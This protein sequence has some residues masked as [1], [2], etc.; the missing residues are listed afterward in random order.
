MFLKC[1]IQ[2]V[3]KTFYQNVFLTGIQFNNGLKCDGNVQSY[4]YKYKEKFYY[5]ILKCCKNIEITFSVIF[6]YSMQSIAA[7]FLQHC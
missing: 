1:F 4:H 6:S 5:N 2:N 7:L 3:I